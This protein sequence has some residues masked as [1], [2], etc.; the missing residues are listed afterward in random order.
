MAVTALD[1]LPDE[2]GQ[3][4]RSAAVTGEHQPA[5]PGPLGL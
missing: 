4:M 1:R 2:L 5:S 3:L